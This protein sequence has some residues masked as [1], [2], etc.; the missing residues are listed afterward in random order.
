MNKYIDADILRKEIERRKELLENGT[1]HPEVMK[2]VE[3]VISAYNSILSFITSHQQE[4][5]EVD[6]EKEFNDFLD[7]V[8]GVPRMWHSDEQIEW[9]KDIAR[10]FYELGRKDATSKFDEI[11]YN[12]QRTEEEMPDKDLD[13]A[14]E[15]YVQKGHLLPEAFI[16][17]PTFKDGAKWQKEQMMK[18]AEEEVVKY[19]DYPE[20][21]YVLVPYEEFNDGDKVRVI[22]VKEEENK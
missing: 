7:N 17:I 16:V 1:A 4:Q 3:G 14:A 18:E 19:N 22:I 8:E 12:R 2:R 15:E 20:Y 11:E 21:K 10:H 9:A 5:Q 13:E 6:L